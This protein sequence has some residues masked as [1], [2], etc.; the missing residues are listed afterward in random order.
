MVEQH[1]AF[2]AGAGSVSVISS[3][4]SPSSVLSGGPVSMPSSYPSVLQATGCENLLLQGNNLAANCMNGHPLAVAHACHVQ[5]AAALTNAKARHGVCDAQQ[6]PWRSSRKNDNVTIERAPELCTVLPPHP[7]LAMR[8]TV[9]AAHVVVAG[10]AVVAVAAAEHGR[11]ETKSPG[12][13]QMVNA[14]R[15]VIAC[16]PCTYSGKYRE[17]RTTCVKPFR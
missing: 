14:G 2:I 8:R 17:C 9:V 13:V 3:S 1:L 4:E 12:L 10:R 5:R 6:I 16:R 11:L 15:Q 7:L